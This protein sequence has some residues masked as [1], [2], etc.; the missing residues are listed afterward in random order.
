[1]IFLKFCSMFHC[2]FSITFYLRPK[3]TWSEHHWHLWEQDTQW[4]NIVINFETNKTLRTLIL[5]VN[6]SDITISLI[7][8]SP[9]GT[10]VLQQYHSFFQFQ[11]HR[12][13]ETLLGLSYIHTRKNI[14][15]L[16]AYLVFQS[17]PLHTI[18]IF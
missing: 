6:S 4:C 10:A 18:N 2:I 14:I 17:A 13:L 8:A 12:N 9:I 5:Q 7:F 11:C 1:M 16:S 15:L 3:K